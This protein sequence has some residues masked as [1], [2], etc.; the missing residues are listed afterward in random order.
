[1]NSINIPNLGLLKP[2]EYTAVPSPQKLEKIARLYADV[3]ADP[4]W[5]EVT[6]CPNR[7]FSGRGVLEICV[8]CQQKLAEAYPVEQTSEKIAE[9]VGKTDGTLISFE[10][11]E[12]KVYAAG[13]GFSCGIQDLRAKYN[14]EDMRNMIGTVLKGK[15][16]TFFYLSE[17][18]VDTK[19]RQQRVATEISRFFLRKANELGWNMVVRTHNE[20]PMARIAN[21]LFMNPIVTEDSEYEGRVLYFK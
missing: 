16:E 3:F 6:V 2:V 17:V 14:T 4:P 18:M 13:W 12:G 15:G 19:A 7:H 20:S 8:K 11:E 10:D 9:E 21:N 5:N 1:M